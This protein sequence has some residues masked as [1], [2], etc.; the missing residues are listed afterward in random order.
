M[1]CSGMR[2]VVGVALA[3]IGLAGFDAAASGRPADDFDPNKYR[4][5]S[6][7][8]PGSNGG[9]LEAEFKVPSGANFKLIGR[10]QDAGWNAK[11][12]IVEFELISGF[13]QTGSFAIDLRKKNSEEENAI[14]AHALNFINP[15]MLKVCRGSIDVKE[16]FQE[17]LRKNAEQ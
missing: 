3:L 1:G 16:R 8:C 11:L 9:V 15:T 14:A 7:F 10:F 5:I 12:E 6:L 2:T 4:Q 17:K 13:D